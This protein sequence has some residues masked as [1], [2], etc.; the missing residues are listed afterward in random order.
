MPPG[1]VRNGN[2]RKA[3]F[4]KRRK[5]HR[6]VEPKRMDRVLWRR[7]TSQQ[8]RSGNVRMEGREEL[9]QATA[10]KGKWRKQLTNAIGSGRLELGF[11]RWQ[12]ATRVFH[13]KHVE[14]WCPPKPM[15]SDL[16]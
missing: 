3:C 12:H 8:P 16:R 7:T 6:D 10:L 13:A 5:C 4:A 14:R 15:S 1:M 9:V 2:I 11:L